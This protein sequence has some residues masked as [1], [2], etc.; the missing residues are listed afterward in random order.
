[1]TYKLL[2]FLPDTSLCLFGDDMKAK[3]AKDSESIHCLVLVAMV[4]MHGLKLAKN[5]YGCKQSLV[6]TLK[7]F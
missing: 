3:N 6:D 5:E 2:F 7:N 4:T 1:M